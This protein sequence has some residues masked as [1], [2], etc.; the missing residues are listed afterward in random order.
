MY[1]PNQGAGFLMSV[2]GAIAVLFI[3]RLLVGRRHTV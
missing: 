2:V 1:G 3:Y